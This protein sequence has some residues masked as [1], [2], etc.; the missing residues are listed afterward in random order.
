VPEPS[1]A[2]L[3]YRQK[4]EA[5]LLAKINSTLEPL[6]GAGKFRAGVSVECDFTAGEQSEES[7]DPTHSVMATSEKTEDA[8]GTASAA[9]VPGI[10]SNLPR[11]TS[12]ASTGAGGTTRRTENVTYQ[13]SRTTRHVK[14]PQGAVKRISLSILLDQEAHWEGQGANAHRVLVAQTAERLKSIR[15][16]LVAA[17]GFVA[18]R[19][20]IVV[21]TLPF[22]K[23]PESGT[24]ASAGAA[25]QERTA[26][27]ARMAGQDSHRP[28]SCSSR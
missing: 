17:T 16:L 23:H 10:A 6:V 27:R 24:A 7:F 18:D 22:E 19:D 20:Q 13:T 21:E 5:D 11:P 3:E 4:I 9:G 2:L 25:G 12:R 15:E 8:T 28:E 14:L 26:A 1:D